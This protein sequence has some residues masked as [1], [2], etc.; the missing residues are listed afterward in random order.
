MRLT[1]VKE[2]SVNSVKFED[3]PSNIHTKKLVNITITVQ[4][5]AK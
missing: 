1:S 4:G 2:F 3:I 5:V